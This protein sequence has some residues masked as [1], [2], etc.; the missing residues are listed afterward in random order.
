MLV[1][2]EHPEPVEPGGLGPPIDL[3]DLTLA[4]PEPASPPFPLSTGRAVERGLG[5]ALPSPSLTMERGNPTPKAR[6]G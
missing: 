4:F 1:P 6:E 3:G 5:V 2:L